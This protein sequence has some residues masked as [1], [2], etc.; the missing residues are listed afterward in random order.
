[1]QVVRTF[2]WYFLS[3]EKYNDR[4]Y[5]DDYW[6]RGKKKRPDQ[7]IARFFDY[8]RLKVIHPDARRNPL[9]SLLPSTLQEA[10]RERERKKHVSMTGTLNFS[11]ESFC[12]LH[13]IFSF[14]LSFLR[15]R[16]VFKK[17]CILFLFLVDF[18]HRWRDSFKQKLIR[19]TN[20]RIVSHYRCVT[21]STGIEKYSMIPWMSGEHT[22]ATNSKPSSSRSC[23]RKR[24][25]KKC[26]IDS[27]LSMSI[28]FSL[29]ASKHL[30]QTMNQ[31]DL[32]DLSTC[33]N[34]LVPHEFYS[35]A[36]GLLS[37]LMDKRF[38]DLSFS[39]LYELR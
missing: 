10:E 2:A 9:Y 34:F 19:E 30:S 23:E 31:L 12:L 3:E 13:H 6:R 33:Q 32:L 15:I 28:C 29:L 21:K 26:C 4:V 8:R 22:M 17:A 36:I 7:S 1:M 38:F 24:K 16:K 25:T 39:K 35:G 5:V 27:L 37:L 11:S 18:F 20:K 14:S